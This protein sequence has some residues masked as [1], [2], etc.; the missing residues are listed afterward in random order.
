[1]FISVLTSDIILEGVKT[2]FYG[3]LLEGAYLSVRGNFK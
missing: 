1:M 3:K 2:L